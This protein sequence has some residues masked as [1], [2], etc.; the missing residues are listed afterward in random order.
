M[1]KTQRYLPGPSITYTTSGGISPQI[2][3]GGTATSA[4]SLSPGPANGTDLTWSQKAQWSQQNSK[5]QTAPSQ[6]GTYTASSQQPVVLAVSGSGSSG[7]VTPQTLPAG[8]WTD[9]SGATYDPV[10]RDTVDLRYAPATNTVVKH[11]YTF[12]TGAAGMLVSETTAVSDTKAYAYDADGNLSSMT[13]T[14]GSSST[15][16]PNR[17]YT[18]DP[19]GRVASAGNTQFGTWLYGYNA[20]GLVS[21]LVE[22]TGGTGI[23]GY[24]YSNSGKM[25]L[26]VAYTLSY[27]GND[28]FSGEQA[29][30]TDPFSRTL[31]YREDGLPTTAWFSQGGTVSRAYTPGGRLTSRTD[32][33]TTDTLAYDTYGR[34]STETTP[35]FQHRV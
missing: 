30:G 7:Q 8:S 18:Y 23:S 20:D 15:A 32:P 27:Y 24:P 25:T 35:T 9:V 34:V 19:D 28:T 2:A 5:N 11:S 3:G 4:P 21:S 17:T 16:T 33:V 22:P 13:F 26:P 1:F 14:V 31:S 12:D 29:A 6:P 10:D